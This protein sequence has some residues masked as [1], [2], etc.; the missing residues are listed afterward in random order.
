M[1][2]CIQFA[3]SH[4]FLVLQSLSRET[5]LTVQARRPMSCGPHAEMADGPEDIRKGDELSR[6]TR[7]GCPTRSLLAKLVP[8]RCPGL[9]AQDSRGKVE[10]A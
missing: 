10:M 3:F 8:F 9:F 6:P 1:W 2:P 5:L 4:Y 7:L